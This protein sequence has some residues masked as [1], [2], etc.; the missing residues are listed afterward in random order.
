MHGA[1]MR[2]TT[3]RKDQ[4]LGPRLWRRLEDVGRALLLLVALSKA[5][6]AECAEDRVDL[7]GPWGQATFSV[8]IADT[9]ETRAQGLMNRTEL[10]RFAGMLFIFEPP[11]RRVHFWMDNTLIPLDMLFFDARGVLTR[12][13]HHARPLDRTP[14]DGGEGVLY[15]L[16]INGG[17]A[18]TLG[19][20]EGSVLRH[21][22][23]DPAQ[24][25]WPCGV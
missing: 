5:A 16:E 20:T 17:L 7:R 18:R 24:A 2:A 9:D 11:P 10:P 4:V 13:H 22:R 8:E 1:E 6:V 15:V 14:I 25:A 12:I 19:I 21:P 3:T 23:I